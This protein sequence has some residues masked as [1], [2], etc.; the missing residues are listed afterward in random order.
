MPLASDRQ[1]KMK[2]NDSGLEKIHKTHI[3][4]VLKA[5]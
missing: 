3:S 2:E 5:A 4:M 1:D